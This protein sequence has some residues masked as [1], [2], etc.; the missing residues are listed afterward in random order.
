VTDDRETSEEKPPSAGRVARRALILSAVVCRG[1]IDNGAG[2]PDAEALHRRI[3]DWIRSLDLQEEPEPEELALLKAPLGT[4]NQ[5]QVV[6]ATWQA[7]G[8]VVLAWA[9]NRIP[10]PKHDEKI[11]PYELTDALDFLSETAG[12]LVQ[13]PDLKTEKEIR[14]L[15]ELL[16]HV[17]V[18]LRDFERHQR[19]TNFARWVDPS[20]LAVLGLDLSGF[21]ADGDLQVGGKAL[22]EADQDLRQTCEWILR[23]RHR[24]SVWLVGEEIT[25]SE[26]TADT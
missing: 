17:H 9:L 10:L 5:N 7:E 23:E 14:A 11:D 4:L 22:S 21:L 26:A 16:Y 3:L 25:N 24:A 2:N 20:D 18:A 6:H 8:L 12:D 15:R 19:P 13:A 1:N